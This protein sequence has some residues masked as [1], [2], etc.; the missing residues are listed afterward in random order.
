MNVEAKA[1]DGLINELTYNTKLRTG[2]LYKKKINKKTNQKQL[3]INATVLCHIQ[4]AAR[5][6][7]S[8]S[9]TNFR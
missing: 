5:V 3:L 1:D 2:I 7:F 8:V 6:P 4:K 9:G